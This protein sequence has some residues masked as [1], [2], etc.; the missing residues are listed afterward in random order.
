M[1]ITEAGVLEFFD[2][3]LIRDSLCEVRF[4]LH[5]D[6]KRVLSSFRDGGYDVLTS[7]SQEN[8][9]DGHLAGCS[10]G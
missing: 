5:I 9:I 10:V 2:G 6:Q 1:R 4:V 7:L 8:W 3:N